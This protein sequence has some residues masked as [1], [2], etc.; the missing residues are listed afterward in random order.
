MLV[1]TTTF[2]LSELLPY[3]S[4]QPTVNPAD[5]TQTQL[6]ELP[7]SSPECGPESSP[8]SRLHV[9]YAIACTKRL[10]AGLNCW[11]STKEDSLIELLT[12]HGAR[13]MR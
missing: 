12:L 9:P 5:Q 6:L 2:F 3:S 1:Y 10:P 13:I 4:P 11:T 7:Y 8:Q